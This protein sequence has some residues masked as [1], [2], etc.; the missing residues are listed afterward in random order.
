MTDGLEPPRVRSSLVRRRAR[1][2]RR[3]DG[4][5]VLA[6]AALL[7]LRLL[8]GHGAAVRREVVEP[9]GDLDV[10][11]GKKLV[12]HGHLGQ[13][14]RGGEGGFF[15]RCRRIFFSIVSPSSV[16][17]ELQLRFQSAVV[18]N[19][20]RRTFKDNATLDW[21]IFKAKFLKKLR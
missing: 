15:S 14:R 9:G 4:V 16:K 2:H 10:V 8:L 6:V 1:H 17:N 5:G 13:E 18:K 19:N 11:V 3:P 12:Q 7:L 20:E 21:E